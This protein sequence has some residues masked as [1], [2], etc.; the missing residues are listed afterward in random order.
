MALAACSGRATMD[1]AADDA[2]AVLEVEN[3]AN[4]DMT[5]YAIREGG[6]RQRLGTATAHL[7]TEFT[8]P[9]S[10]LFGVTSLRFQADPIGGDRA[11]VTQ[12]ITVAPGD[13]VVMRIPPG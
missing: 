13:V 6:Q 11:P 9:S 1:G 2:P 7:T 10:M 12:S 3:H 5:I 4:L 8:I